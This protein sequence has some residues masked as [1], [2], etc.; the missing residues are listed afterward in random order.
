MSH[1]NPTRRK[2]IFNPA[3]SDPFKISRSKIDMFIQCKRCFY[4]DQRL[5]VGRPKTPPFTLNSAVDKLLKK[6]FD[7]HRA[8]KTPHPL[9]EAHAVLAVPFIHADLDKWRHNFTG[10]QYL[11]K[12][13]NM[14][15]YGAIDDVWENRDGEL[16]VVDY[17]ATAKD[18]E[19]TLEDE[20]KQQYKRQMEV[21]QWLL[22]QNGFKVNDTG[23][24][25]YVNGQTDRAG[26]HGKLEFNIQ[27]LPYTGKDAWVP[28]AL[29]S[30]KKCLIDDR[31]PEAA[32]T[33]DYCL[34][35]NRYVEVLRSNKA[36]KTM[37]KT[38]PKK[39]KKKE[40]EPDAAAEAGTSLF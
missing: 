26:F 38:A 14:M 17:K 20:W 16:I 18:T 2:F 30:I 39:A 22:R 15:V 29:T 32:E 40:S 8:A 28:E 34:Y 9:M 4:L 1:Y 36:A 7:V 21:Y 12:E 5:G 35:L 27:L 37:A 25:V 23:Y 10:V 13:L 19:I 6:E 31:I 33:C 3:S 24:F 11:D